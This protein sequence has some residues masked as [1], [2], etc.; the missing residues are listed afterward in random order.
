[1]PL[2]SGHLH[3]QGPESRVIVVAP[4]IPARSATHPLPKTPSSTLGG[5]TPGSPILSDSLSL[6]SAPS[7]VSHTTPCPTHSSPTRGV[8]VE[9]ET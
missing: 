8:E 5:T 9:I 6:S 2:E 1:M 7:S 3:L 4:A